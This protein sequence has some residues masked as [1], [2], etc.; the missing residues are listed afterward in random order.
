VEEPWAHHPTAAW[1]PEGWAVTWTAAAEVRAA[2]L[3]ADGGVVDLGA[4]DG[5]KSDIVATGAGWTVG[6][7]E[8]DQAM[9]ARTLDVDGTL[10]PRVEL[11]PATAVPAGSVDVAAAAETVWAL[12]YRGHKATDA[13]PADTLPDG[14]YRLRAVESD[15]TT[16]EQ[17][18]PWETPVRSGSAPALAVGPQGRLWAA[19]QL[20][21][22]TFDDGLGR[23]PER[24][25]LSELVD[26]Q[27]SGS[28]TVHDGGLERVSRPGV[29]VA[30]DGTIAVL[31]RTGDEGATDGWIRR[32][33]A[34]LRPLD[35]AQLLEAGADHPAIAAHPDGFQVA[36]EH[37]VA[38]RDGVKDDRDVFVGVLGTDGTWHR[39]PGPVLPAGERRTRP[40]FAV[41]PGGEV[42]LVVEVGA[43]RQTHVM[44][45]LLPDPPHNR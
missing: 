41:A 29:A 34:A 15:G 23:Y 39:A 27:P 24:V 10:G 12:W 7:Q 18:S 45:H 40:A 19:V 8:D 11:Q 42:M 43:Y 4:W 9:A 36:W 33:D 38:R 37:P 28:V 32:F 2:V 14:Q 26:G 6:W 3:Q 25:E 16:G 17:T 5:L 31:W 21:Y 35:E 1:G 22:G 44:A 13:R 30:D 20:R